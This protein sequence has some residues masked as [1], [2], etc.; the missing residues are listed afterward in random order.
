MQ[1]SPRVPARALTVWLPVTVAL[2]FAWWLSLQDAHA[3]LRVFY[4]AGK[5]VLDG[6]SPYP[7]LG[8]AEVYS[9][10]AFVYPIAAV[11]PFVPLALLPWGLA[12][13]VFYALSAAAVVYAV[14]LTGARAAAPYLAVFLS[15]SFVRSA[16][17]G[18]LNALL[19]AGLLVAWH[20]REHVAP[21]VAILTAV[22]VPKLFLVPLLGWP[23]VLRRWKATALACAAIGAILLAGFAVGPLSA[24]DYGQLLGELSGRLA[25]KGWG[26]Y[27]LLLDAGGSA[28]V[29]RAGAWAI[30]GAI[31]TASYG[32]Y[33]RHRAEVVLFSGAIVAAILA[34]PIVWTHY[35]LLMFAPLLVAGLRARWLVGFA[36]VTWIFSPPMGTGAVAR[37]LLSPY[38]SNTPRAAILVA[39]LLASW[40]LVLVM[41]RAPVPERELQPQ[42]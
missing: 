6:E 38:D 4:D 29:A 20:Y 9:E 11:L 33:L 18:T 36:V 27:R 34:S 21:L 19:L 7:H 28:T 8:T 35:Y 3:D 17:L 30:A 37:T 2:V 31:L 10:H 15:A 13:F 14:R 24:G 12:K 16:Q 5:S 39:M 40:V 41:T 1:P 26:P 23:F 25:Q 22:I 32:W 42:T